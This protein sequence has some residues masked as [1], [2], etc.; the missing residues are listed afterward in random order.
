[1]RVLNGPHAGERGMVVS[2]EGHQCV[3]LPDTCQ[4]ELKVFVRDLT[5]ATESGTGELT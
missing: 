5:E 2:V 4:A 1:M 3:L